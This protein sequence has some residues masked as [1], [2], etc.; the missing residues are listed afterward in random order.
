MRVSNHEARW[1]ILRDASRSLS[2]GA[3][4]RDPL[5]MR[6]KMRTDSNGYRPTMTPITFGAAR[7]FSSMRARDA[8]RFS[9]VSR[10]RFSARIIQQ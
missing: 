3:H 9:G 5:A 8:A 2:S 1:A 6:L 7:Y 10:P 4:S